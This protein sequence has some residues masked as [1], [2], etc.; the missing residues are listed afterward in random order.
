MVDRWSGTRTICAS[1]A[2]WTCAAESEASECTNQQ[3]SKHK[4]H[5][6]PLTESFHA[7][8]RFISRLKFREKSHAFPTATYD[9][10]RYPLHL[11]LGIARAIR[12]VVMD[13]VDQ[14][15]EVYDRQVQLHSLPLSQS[16][17]ESPIIH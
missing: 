13:V 9:V 2:R 3:T 12:R 11:A 7:L 8:F 16:A 5:Q 1:E 17:K 14:E 6:T 4:A 15:A 10:K